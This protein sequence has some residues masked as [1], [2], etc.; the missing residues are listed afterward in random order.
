MS[1]TGVRTDEMWKCTVASDSS[2]CPSP[3]FH[4]VWPAGLL[5]THCFREESFPEVEWIT[6]LGLGGLGCPHLV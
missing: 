2:P 6:G 3:S 4:A 1:I 5:G